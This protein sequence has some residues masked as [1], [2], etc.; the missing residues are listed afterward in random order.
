MFSRM[1]KAGF[2]LG[3]KTVDQGTAWALVARDTANGFITTTRHALMVLGGAAIAVLALMFVKPDF[4]DHVKALSPFAATLASE[5][6]AAPDEAVALLDMPGKAFA[7]P[8]M[9]MAADKHATAH[10]ALAELEQ[11]LKNKP[12]SQEQQWVATWLSKRYRVAGDVTH[13]L[14]SAAYKT[15]D[16][17][18]LDPLLILAVAAIESRLN[19][20][21]ESPVGAQGVMQVMSKIH[22]EKFRDLG[23]I[24]AA[25]NPVANIKVGSQILKEYVRRGGSVEAGLKM[26]VGAALMETDQGYGAKVLAEYRRL[27]EVASGKTVPLFTTTASKPAAKPVEDEA[28]VEQKAVQINTNKSAAFSPVKPVVEHKDQ[29]YTL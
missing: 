10:V 11:K 21:A 26:Y 1:I 20:Y 29:G 15:A 12:L 17:L 6:D 3:R 14:V 25:L 23:G 22:Q 24:K 13:V 5:S 27:Q 8:N 7:Q 16:E 9:N 19:P 4:T 2:S 18:Q 28:A